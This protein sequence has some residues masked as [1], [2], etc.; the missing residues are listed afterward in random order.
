MVLIV[1]II[2]LAEAAATAPQ[3]HTLPVVFD[4]TEDPTL[5]NLTR[6]DANCDKT[7]TCYDG[8]S[9]QMVNQVG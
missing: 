6:T 4:A 8:K 1:R 9:Y 7:G 3:D 5:N 2:R